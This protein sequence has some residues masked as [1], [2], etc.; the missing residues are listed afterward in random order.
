MAERVL[1]VDPGTLRMGY[2]VVESS[3]HQARY[4]TA[5]AIIPRRSLPLG[6]RLWAL[7]QELTTLLDTW[8]PTTLAVEEPFV[9]RTRADGTGSS[10]RSAMALGQAE[11]LVLMAA[12]ARGI[13][14]T[15]YAPA[16]IKSAVT[17]DG[18]GSKEQV[19]EM[20]RL[21]LGLPQRPHPADAADALAVALCHI[22]HQRAARLVGA[23]RA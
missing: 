21:I 6:D 9:P 20:V 12:A 22:Q 14:V 11:A 23:G 19:Q 5:G 4:L 8:T 13:P 1:G 15:R 10:V 2:G 7:F 16:Q 3:G 18:R 17:N